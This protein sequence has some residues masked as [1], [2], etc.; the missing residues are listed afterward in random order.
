MGLKTEWGLVLPDGTVA[1]GSYK[2]HPLDTPQDRARML[3][4]LRQTAADLSFPE[5]TFLRH[6]EW[7]SRTVSDPIPL[8][9]LQAL[10]GDTGPPE[11]SVE[12]TPL[13]DSLEGLLS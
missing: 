10:C 4:V 6:Y 2:E 5:E 1:W 8:T 12:L 13:P 9:D 11:E 7:T 3:L